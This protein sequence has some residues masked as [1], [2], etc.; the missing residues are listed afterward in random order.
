[1]ERKRAEE[2]LRKADR[3]KDEFLAMLGHELRNPLGVIKTAAYLLR[4]DGPPDP[5]LA[6]LRETIELEVSQMARLLDDLLDISR[7][8]RGLI[9]LKKEPC[10]LA[11]IVRQVVQSRRPVLEETG[12]DL[13]L[14]VPAQPLWV[15][16]DRTRLAQ[17]M[18]NLLDNA[19]KFTDRGGQVI[20]RLSEEL[21]EKAA[22]LIVRDSGIGIEPALLA[23]VFE[24]FIQADKSLDRSRSG[25]GLGLALVKGLVELQSGEV[26]ALSD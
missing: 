10:D 26:R 18:G 20:V 9:R 14:D 15:I 1:M 7:I 6:H 25:L 22:I 12:L 17:I 4:T 16:G 8:E 11:A 2:A 24:P 13:S 23:L 21:S 3:R 19:N 5:E